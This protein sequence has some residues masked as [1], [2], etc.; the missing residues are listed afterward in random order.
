MDICILN[1]S[2]NF[3]PDPDENVLQSIFKQY[4]YV[5]VH[6]IITSFGMDFLVKDRHGGDVDTIH[7]VRNIG[8]D[9]KMKYKN[10]NNAAD[11]NSM[12]EYSKEIHI[13][14][15]RDKNFTQIKSDARKTYN[16]TGQPIKDGYTGG[17]L[18]Y[19]KSA[20]PGSRA[21]LDHV[22][23]TK[24][25]YNDRGRVLAGVDGKELANSPDNLVFTNKSL[26]ASMRA[27]EIPEYIAAHPELD[28]KT[29][30]SMMKHYETATK[31]Y[32][33]KLA[34]AYYTSPKFASDTAKAAGKV[35]VQ[36]GLRQLL[37][38]VF[39]E[40]WFSIKEEFN[41]LDVH[42][43]LDLDLGDF[44]TSV[45]N[46]VKN[47]LQNAKSKYKELFAQFAQG[48]IA[49]ALSSLTTTLCNIF[50]TTAKNIVKVIR[51]SFA[52]IVEAGKI[53]LINPQNYPLGER[54]RAATKVLAT[55]ASVVLGGLV[56]E[57]VGKTPIAAIPVVGDIVVTFCGTLCTGI[58][59]CTLL[60]FLDR[61]K[62]INSIVDKLNN[63][64]TIE[65]DVNYFKRQAEL[66]EQF[67]AELMKI[68][69]DKFKKETAAFSS[70]A[71]KISSATSEENLN[72]I[73]KKE[74]YVLGIKPCWEGTHDSFDSF[75]RDKNAR[76]IFE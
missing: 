21:E 3:D 34:R 35:G 56:S 24:T 53:L 46:G 32:E 28:E 44:F 39:T 6:S 55:G 57:A 13:E 42:F 17:D 31:N 45:G 9:E 38:F 60:Y 4:E 29:K 58:V 73:L 23:S 61:S 66:F 19:N 47:G 48:S 72:N 5:I 18:H 7:N 76:M 65:D 51:Q 33:V 74:L 26:N 70:A 20:D 16:E 2:N 63:L 11:Y 41:R 62:I 49:G 69:I 15:H 68:D 50:F 1:A 54:M 37:G 59:S 25:I 75:M 67:A 8:I 22:K 12:P 64:H 14:Y 71:D 52:S 30:K 27:M 40:I 36:M 43:G 10:S